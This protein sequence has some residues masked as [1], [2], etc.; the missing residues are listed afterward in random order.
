MLSPE[1][2]GNSPSTR[3]FR[4]AKTLKTA[5]ADAASDD[6][7]RIGPSPAD[8]LEVARCLAEDAPLLLI[9]DEF[10]KN[11]EAISD[12][13]DADPY[14]LQ[15]LAEA[16]QGAGLPIFALTLQ[17]LSFEDYLTST[18]GPQRREW[19]KVQGRFEDVAYIESAAQTRAL[20]GTVFAD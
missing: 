10:G 12:G 18:D 1:T 8:L 15:Q 17:H 14:L 20:I 13:S 16:G 6:P 4:A 2:Y 5:L 11:L 3:T 9:I 19:A 7:R